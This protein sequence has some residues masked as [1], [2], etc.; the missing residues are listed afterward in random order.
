M[1][2]WLKKYY[3]DNKTT[4]D[5]TAAKKWEHTLVKVLLHRKYRYRRHTGKSRMT[6]QTKIPLSSS[7]SLSKIYDQANGVFDLSEFS[8][9]NEQLMKACVDMVLKR[10]ISICITFINIL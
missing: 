5:T 10:G 7:S 3:D 9:Q 1:H 2:K 8:L 4:E 6:L